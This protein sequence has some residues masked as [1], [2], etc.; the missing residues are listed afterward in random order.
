MC[1]AVSEREVANVNYSMASFSGFLANR[2]V[3]LAKGP[4]GR[5]MACWE[6]FGR[7]VIAEVCFLLLFVAALVETVARALI[8][9][10]AILPL[11]LFISA[12]DCE[13]SIKVFGSTSVQYGLDTAIRCLAAL[14]FN[15]KGGITKYPDLGLC[16][17]QLWV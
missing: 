14:I 9:L 11:T 5:E 17:M 6:A 7:R 2:T 12:A 3:A 1:I 4:D 15:V 16:E 13:K 10:I 8:L